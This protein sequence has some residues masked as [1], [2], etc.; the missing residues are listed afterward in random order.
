[1][2]S[3]AWT[4]VADAD[5]KTNEFADCFA[6][7]VYADDIILV[8]MIDRNYSWGLAFSGKK[9]HLKP[10]SRIPLK[11]RID[12]SPWFDATAAVV[13]EN[14]VYLPMAEETTL[15]ELF[16]HGRVLQLYDGGMFDFDLTGTAR[17]MIDL[18]ACVQ[19]ELSGLADRSSRSS[20]TAR[21]G[22][23]DG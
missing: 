1:F 18:A 4:V 10:G 13:A 14:M 5:D 17:L 3:G 11:F 20:A 9:W 12:T 22:S 15:V 8:V 16:R 7:T 6:A 2:P 19:T 23:P 21:E